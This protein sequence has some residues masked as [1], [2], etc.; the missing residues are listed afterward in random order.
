[1][2]RAISSRRNLVASL[3]ATAGLFHIVP[4]HVLGRGYRAPS[5]TL[6]IACIGVGG[7]MW[8]ADSGTILAGMYGEEQRLL[9]PAQDPALMANPPAQKY[10]RSHGVYAG[11]I[12]A[13]KC[14]A[15]NL[16]TFPRHAGA[17]T[18]MVLFGCLAVRQ[19]Q[20]LTIDPST[21][22]ITNVK[23]PE[24]WFKPVYRRGWTL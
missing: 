20:P 24:E 3:S 15:P 23:L 1:M 13:V 10:Q 12:R 14:G 19:G 22:T 6:N 2:P 18:E 4:R 7:Q 11:R 21:G 9:D 16:S 5:D 8:L 17:L